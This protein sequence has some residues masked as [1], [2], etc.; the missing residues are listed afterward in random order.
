MGNEFNVPDASGNG[1]ISGG[2]NWAT[3][4]HQSNDELDTRYSIKIEKTNEHIQGFKDFNEI[5]DQ[6]IPDWMK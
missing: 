5:I 2:S 4:I 1:N 6:K 3:H